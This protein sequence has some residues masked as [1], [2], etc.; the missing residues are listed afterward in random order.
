MDL[1]SDPFFLGRLQQIYFQSE[2]LLF[3]EVVVAMSV[4][5]VMRL[6][7]FVDFWNTRYTDRA[8]K[9]NDDVPLLDEV[10]MDLINQKAAISRK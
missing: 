1:S 2:D 8:N 5:V 4:H 3:L 10:S 9:I 6:R 7:M